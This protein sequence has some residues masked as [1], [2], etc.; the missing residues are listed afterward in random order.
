MS[1]MQSFED[2]H[3][4]GSQSQDELTPSHRSHQTGTLNYLEEA[5]F[6]PRT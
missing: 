2:V 4:M 6:K 3:R 5:R 1:L